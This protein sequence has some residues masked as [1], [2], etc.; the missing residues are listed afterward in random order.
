[1]Q[2]Y[3]KVQKRVPGQKIKILEV[4]AGTGATTEWVLRL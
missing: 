3:K 2:N 4:G 1:M